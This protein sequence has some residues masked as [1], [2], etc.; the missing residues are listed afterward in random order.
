[1]SQKHVEWLLGRLT[2]DRDFRGRFYDD[3]A[4]ICA[5]ESVELTT[6][7][8]AALLSLEE[9]YIEEFSKRLDPRIV[10]SASTTNRLTRRATRATDLRA[11]RWRGAK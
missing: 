10:R 4:A 1:M 7:E 3:P 2:T 6:Q 11:G 5:R 9:G 8:L